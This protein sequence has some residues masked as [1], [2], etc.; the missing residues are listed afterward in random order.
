MHPVCRKDIPAT[1][2]IELWALITIG[3]KQAP[4]KLILLVENS[5]TKI[6]DSIG[7]P[8]HQTKIQT[9]IDT[10]YIYRKNDHRTPALEASSNSY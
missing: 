9:E 2:K 4:M 6:Q 8:S 7:G 10:N 3:P 1:K 5:K